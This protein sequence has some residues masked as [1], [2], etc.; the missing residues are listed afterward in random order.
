MLPCLQGNPAWKMAWS[1][2]RNQQP[3]EHVICATRSLTPAFSVYLRASVSVLPPLALRPPSVLHARNH[4]D[5]DEEAEDESEK[6]QV[7]ASF[8]YQGD[9]YVVATPLE[10]VLIIGEARRWSVQRWR[11]D[12]TTA[13][14]VCM[15]RYLK[16]RTYTC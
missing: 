3:E 12:S 16:T 13:R 2:K 4:Q 1:S 6:V 10:P 11:L 14:S 9:K 5:S 8:Y 7:L 15:E